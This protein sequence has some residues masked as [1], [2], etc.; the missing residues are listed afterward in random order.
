[1]N[2]QN[3]T[4][5][6]EVP[7]LPESK[8]HVR[9]NKRLSAFVLFSLISIILLNTLGFYLKGASAQPAGTTIK[10]VPSQQ[11]VGNANQQIPTAGL[12]FTINVTVTNVTNLQAWQFSIYYF[13][14]IVNWT[15]ATIPTE[16]IFKGK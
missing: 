10:I 2:E 11:T 16:N 7:N 14:S 6:A 5:R 12:P 8:Q 3:K 9:A 15:T 4:L 1:M 13:P